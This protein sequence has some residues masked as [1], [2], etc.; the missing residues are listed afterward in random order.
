MITPTLEKKAAIHPISAPLA[1]D[2]RAP[3]PRFSRFLPSVAVVNAPLIAVFLITGKLWS[4][5]SALAG[6]AISLAACG[7]LHLFVEKV[8]PFLTAGVIGQHRSLEQ[9]AITQFLGM[10]AAKFLLLGVVGYVLL[11]FREVNLPMVLI[12]FAL[13]QTTIV[14]AAARYFKKS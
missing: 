11:N 12:G 6:V 4:V 13:T 2:E 10:V 3:L 1:S 7:L 8:M 9:G 14:V 5:G